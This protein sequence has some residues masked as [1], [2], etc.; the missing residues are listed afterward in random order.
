[1]N[2]QSHSKTKPQLA[3]RIVVTWVELTLVGLVGGIIGTS[4][5]GPPGLI[6]YFITTLASVGIVF[7]NVNQLI[8]QWIALSSSDGQDTS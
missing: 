6:V 5:G 1:M 7:Y 8:Q 3:S 2:S 4:I